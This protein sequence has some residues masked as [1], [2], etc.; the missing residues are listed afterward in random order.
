MRDLGRAGSPFAP[1]ETSA[2]RAQIAALMRIPG[3]RVGDD[4]STSSA[5]PEVTALTNTPVSKP[6][7]SDALDLGQ[8]QTATPPWWEQ[9]PLRCWE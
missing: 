7:R 9:V 3:I 5:E 2:H 8:Y 1:K 4:L 6:S